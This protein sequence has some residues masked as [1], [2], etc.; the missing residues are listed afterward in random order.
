MHEIGSEFHRMPI[1]MGRGLE[2][3]I[4][5]HLVF[6]GRTAIE[7]VLR[8][9][10]GARRALLPSYCCDSMIKPFRD[11]GMDIRF[12]SVN[13]DNGLSVKFENLEDIDVLLW[14]NYFGF[15]VSEPD[16]HNFSG[17]IIEDITH[18]LLSDN[19]YHCWSKYLVASLRKWEPINCGGYFAKIRESTQHGEISE[20]PA[21]FITARTSAMWLKTEYLS[22]FDEDKK[23]KFLS[24][25]SICNHWLA[26]NYSNLSIDSWSKRYLSKVDMHRQVERRRNNATVL[27]NGLK[28]KVQFLFRE[29]D[30][31]CP[32]FVPILL[33]DRDR[34]RQSLTDNG[35]YCPVHWPRPNGCESNLYDMELSLVCDQRYTE[36]D[37]KYVVSILLSLL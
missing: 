7:M 37:M 31:G 2:L 30:M 29:S 5:G 19:S 8:E 25:F 34:V 3:P 28:G 13:Y 36:E 14:C 15:N 26:E 23:A 21:W 17:V 27:Y 11:A 22:D 18:S 10:H 1:E 4:E 9:I 6:Y 35:I 24:M 12:Y 20:P 33:S 16:L 32:I